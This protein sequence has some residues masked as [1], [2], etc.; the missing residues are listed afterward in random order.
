MTTLLEKGRQG[1]SLAEYEIVDMHAHLMMGPVPWGEDPADHLVRA[2]DQSG[3]TLAAV[4][5]LYELVKEQNAVLRAENRE[6]KERLDRLENLAL[7][8]SQ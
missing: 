2:M 1:E 7:S 8:D 6:L 5:G 3:V 4:Q